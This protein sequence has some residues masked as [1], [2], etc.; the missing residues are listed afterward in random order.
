MGRAQALR[1]GHGEVR[2]PR[3][4][5]G[6]GDVRLRSGVVV[7]GARPCR[8]GRQAAH[9]LRD[10]RWAVDLGLRV[11]VAADDGEQ[12]RERLL[13]HWR[14]LRRRKAGRRRVRMRRPGHTH[15]RVERGQ[16][17]VGDSRFHQLRRLRLGVRNPARVASVRVASGPGRRHGPGREDGRQGHQLRRSLRVFA[18]ARRQERQR[19]FL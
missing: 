6:E 5:R 2:Q 11:G 13:G 18:H 17:P 8:Q 10:E 16:A 7:A 12:N 1:R 19:R 14:L 15:R 3:H 4:G 9:R